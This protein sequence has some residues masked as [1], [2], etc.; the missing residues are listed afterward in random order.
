MKCQQTLTSR[1]EIGSLNNNY[2][3]RAFEFLEKHGDK[4]SQ[5]GAIEVGLRILPYRPDL[6]SHVIRLIEQVCDDDVDGSV[7]GLKLF[8]ALFILVEGE[9]SRTRLMATVPPFYRRLASLAQ[10]A[11][12]HRQFVDTGVDGTFCE[13]ALN[14]RGER[15]YWQSLADMRLEPRW[16]P[17]FAAALQMKA[18]F[19][20]RIMIAAA[21]YVKNL[22]D[23]ELHTLTLGTESNSLLSLCQL[24]QAYLPG[25]LEGAEGSAHALPDDLSKAIEEQLKT[26]EISPFSFIALVNSAPIFRVDSKQVEL[27][28]KNLKLGNH[29]LSRVEDKL[30][31]LSILNGLATVAAATRSTALAD[32]L[33]ILIRRYRHDTQYVFSIEMA[34]K[35]CLIASAS[36]KDLMQWCEFTGEW[37]TELAFDELKGDDGKILLSHLNCLLHAVP[38]LWVYCGKADAAL[39]AFCFR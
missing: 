5:L 26:D 37:L 25:P 19:L 33:R 23:H 13:W 10:A 7:K 20:G 3:V 1:I 24:P 32:E 36:R 17:D 6:E 21:N 29:R 15:F 14:N 4:L 16:N 34:M 18:D 12:I 35:I 39:K 2:L 31:L 11:L 8:S 38:E 28:I 27:A 30:Q 22:E 9:L